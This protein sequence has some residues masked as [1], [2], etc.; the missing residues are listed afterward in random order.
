MNTMCALH[1]PTASVDVDR[2]ARD[3]DFQSLQQN[4]MNVTFCNIE[5]EVLKWVHVNG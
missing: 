5:S 3:M 2:I 4:M 1:L